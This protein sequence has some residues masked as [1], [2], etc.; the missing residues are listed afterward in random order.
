MEPTNNDDAAIAEFHAAAKRRRQRIMGVT[1]VLCLLI[2][3]AILVVT[4]T[5]GEANDEGGRMEGR[6]LLVGIAFVVAGFVSG[7]MAI[8]GD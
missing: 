5:A 1:A 3:A 2:G 6:T 4:F 8:K 7:G